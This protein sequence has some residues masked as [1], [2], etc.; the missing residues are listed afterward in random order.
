MLS[1]VG[2]SQPCPS[3]EVPVQEISISGTTQMLAMGASN[4]ASEP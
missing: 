1:L 2:D 3:Y 4:E